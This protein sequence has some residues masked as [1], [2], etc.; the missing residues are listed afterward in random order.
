MRDLLDCDD[1]IAERRYAYA[2]AAARDSD[3]A[4]AEVLEQTLEL[5][6]RARALA[7]GGW[8][9]FSGE[10]CEGEGYRLGPI[11]R[12]AHSDP[13]VRETRFGPGGGDV[14][15]RTSRSAEKRIST[16]PGCSAFML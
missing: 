7:N 1:P 16:R 4:A 10:T 8:L 15:S 12:F 2:R 5:A 3:W 14:S 6:P 13:Y 11:M 9:A